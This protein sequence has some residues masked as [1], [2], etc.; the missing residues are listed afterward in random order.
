MIVVCQIREQRVECLVDVDSVHTDTIAKE[1]YHGLQLKFRRLE[2][3]VLFHEIESI[4]KLPFST[5]GDQHGYEV[6][7]I[8]LKKIVR[9]EEFVYT[10]PEKL[11][12][13]RFR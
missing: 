9:T 4:L 2:H 10:R 6:T 1:P 12:Q 3:A 5:F 13:V 11:A 8:L 7:N